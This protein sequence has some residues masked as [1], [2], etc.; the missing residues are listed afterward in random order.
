MP[1]SGLI[2]VAKKGSGAQPRWGEGRSPLVGP[3][4]AFG[5]LWASDCAASLR[6]ARPRFASLTLHTA[7]SMPCEER[8][9][10]CPTPERRPAASVRTFCGSV[11]GRLSAWALPREV[12]WN[13]SLRRKRR[14]KNICG[15]AA[16]GITM[17]GGAWW[18]ICGKGW[19]KKRQSK[20]R[21]MN[22]GSFFMAEDPPRGSP[23]PR[24]A[25]A[26]RRR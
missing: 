17:P 25:A 16:A 3:L 20:S 12:S 8:R 7:H 11:R 15:A 21:G 5:K 1:R 19:K 24:K 13:T 10:I 18:R 14:R 9:R 23:A 26:G 6:R 4:H 2:A 22:P